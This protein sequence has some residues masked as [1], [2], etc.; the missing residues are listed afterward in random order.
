MPTPPTEATLMDEA[1][2]VSRRQMSIAQLPK[3][4]VEGVAA[5]LG[6]KRNQLIR[7]ARNQQQAPAAFTPGARLDAVRSA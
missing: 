2:A 7:Y 6:P 4:H 1:L 3:T 5:Y